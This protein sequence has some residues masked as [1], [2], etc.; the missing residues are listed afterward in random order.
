MR[1]YRLFIP[2]LYIALACVII[3]LATICMTTGAIDIPPSQVWAA[4]TGGH[5]DNRVW[6]VIVTQSRLPQTVTALM[7]GAALACGGLLLQTLFANPLA[8]PSILGVSSGA[9]LGV[10]A[11]MLASGGAVGSLAGALST[12]A[13]AMVGAMAVL[14]LIIALSAVVRSNVMLLVVGLMI[15]YMASSAVSLFSFMGAA[16]SVKSFSVWGMGDFG[17]VSLTRLPY[18]V[19][20][21]A[22]GLLWALLMMKPMNAMLLGESYCRNLGVNL[23]KLR[24]SVLLSTGLLTAVVTAFCGPVSFIGLAVPHMARLLTGT[25]DHR[26]LMP[27]VML[28]GA[29]VALACNLLTTVFGEG[30]LLPLNVVTP[31]LGAPV[32]IYVI[33]NKRKI[34]YFN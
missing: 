3:A 30:N 32:I 34:A 25:S 13:G 21:T 10:A 20:I 9:G 11:V 27:V 14:A 4:L 15:G 8:D 12:V 24:V 17:G 5:V 2:L 28:L 23:K 7:A 22:A 33:V 26:V 29:A 6:S 16:E 19:A 1:H 31:L 18:F